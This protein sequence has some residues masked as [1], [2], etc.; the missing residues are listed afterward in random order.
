MSTGH[1]ELKP[2]R[3]NSIAYELEQCP[4]HTNPSRYITCLPSRKILVRQR[5]TVALVH[6][7]HNVIVR[8][9][10]TGMLH[11]ITYESIMCYLQHTIYSLGYTAM[12]KTVQWLK[13]NHQNCQMNNK[14][15]LSKTVNVRRKY[16]SQC[17]IPSWYK[18]HDPTAS[19]GRPNI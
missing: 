16:V 15:I 8:H 7:R 17:H 4:S 1:K 6:V 11:S 18:S 2:K 9:I 3:C 13:Q 5:V 19:S 10:A 12:L 14:V